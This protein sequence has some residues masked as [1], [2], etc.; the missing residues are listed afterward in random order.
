MATPF[1]G[2][3]K[4]LKEAAKASGDKETFQ[5]LLL[6]AI[7]L[8]DLTDEG[9]AGR[10]DTSRPTVN[11]W[12]NGSNAPHPALRPAVYEWLLELA[13]ARSIRYAKAEQQEAEVEAQRSNP[14]TRAPS[15]SENA[16]AARG[17]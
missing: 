9:I 16:M 10:F 1:D 17:K 2:L 5:S 12:R 7:K 4:D 15:Y 6:A 8:L 3:I 13:E 11:R 14:R